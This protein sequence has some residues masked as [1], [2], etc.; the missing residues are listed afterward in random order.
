MANTIILTGLEDMAEKQHQLDW[1]YFKEGIEIFPLSYHSNNDPAS[2]LLRY[3]AGAEVP[4]HHH[5]GYEHIFVLDGSQQ[6][7]SG[8]YE[9]GSLLI[10]PPGSR[11]SVRSESGCIVFAVWEKTVEFLQK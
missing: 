9:K 1:Q 4:S 11:H 8:I 5:P 6:D 10:S 3:Q 7:E 2:A